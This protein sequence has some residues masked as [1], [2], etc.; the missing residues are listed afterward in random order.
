MTFAVNTG[1]TNSNPLAGIKDALS[2][3]AVDNLPALKP[4]ELPSLM[5]TISGANRKIQT[6]LLMEWQ[7]ILCVDR[8]KRLAQCG[9][10]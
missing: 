4:E 6:R 9:K 10:K 8:V 3:P 2:S 5:K 7:Y 1:L